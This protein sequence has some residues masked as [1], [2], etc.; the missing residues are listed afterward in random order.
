MKR[1]WA[2]KVGVWEV[3]GCLGAADWEGGFPPHACRHPQA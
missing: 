3:S 2:L 1:Q